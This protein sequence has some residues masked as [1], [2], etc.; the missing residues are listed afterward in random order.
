MNT[1]LS[2]LTDAEL[3]CESKNWRMGRNSYCSLRDR[4]QK[5]A[6]IISITARPCKYFVARLQDTDLSVHIYDAT[7]ENHWNDIYYWLCKRGLYD[8]FEGFGGCHGD[9]LRDNRGRSESTSLME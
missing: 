6:P 2:N 8:Q 3:S 1:E 5:S 9:R 4:N 7:D